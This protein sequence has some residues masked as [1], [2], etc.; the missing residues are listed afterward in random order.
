V[1]FSKRLQ[2]R[3]FAGPD[4]TL[5]ND[6]V[7]PNSF[8]FRTRPRFARVLYF[9][10]IWSKHAQLFWLKSW[11]LFWL[12][13][14]KER[15]PKFSFH[16]HDCHQSNRLSFPKFHHCGTW[17][18]RREIIRFECLCFSISLR[19]NYKRLRELCGE[20]ISPCIYL[21]KKRKQPWFDS[22]CKYHTRKVSSS[23]QGG[24]SIWNFR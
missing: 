20:N 14:M 9:P 19:S 21:W 18:M 7:R 10:V 15:V 13:K 5:D 11:Y 8:R 16:R 12:E 6:G 2:E 17:K 1:I 22:I 24:S 4:V 3:R 23:L